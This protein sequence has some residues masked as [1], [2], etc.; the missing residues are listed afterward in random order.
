MESVKNPTEKVMDELALSWLKASERAENT[1]IFIW[2][3]P[4]GG[5]S[6]LEGF[7]ALQQHPQGRSLPDMFLAMTTPF[8]TGYGY[9]AALGR[10]FV[11][12]YE[13][14]PD[15]GDWD[16]E[17][18]LPCY[19]AAR[20][21]QLLQSF[22][23]A[24][25][26]A[27][28][29]LILVL[30][31]QTISDRS[32]CMR[33]LTRWLEQREIAPRLLLIDSLEQ[34][35]WQPLHQSHPHRVQLIVD[36]V[37]T[38]KVMHLTAQQLSDPDA[39]RLQFRRYLADAMLLLEKGGAEQV[40]AR[41]NMAL[42]IAR[43]RGW[44]DQQAII[45]NLMAGG[46]LKQGDHARAVEHYRQATDA[47]DH[48]ADPALKGQLRTQSAFGEAG[49]WFSKQ[50]YLQA[51]SGYRQAAREAQAIPHPL[52][53][54]EGWRMSGFCLWLAGHHARAMEEYALAVRAGRSIAA[55]ERGQSTLP[56]VFQD[57]LRIHDKPRTEAIEAC[58]ARWQKERQ[59]LIRQAEDSVSATPDITRVKQAEKRLQLQLEAAF[60]LIR[61]QRETLIA[62]SDAHFRR[63]IT[64]ARES[65][66]PHWNGLP[67]I[68]HPYDAPPGEW[69]TLP[70]WGSGSTPST[71]PAGSSSS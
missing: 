18:Y 7:I 28:R 42:D 68:A 40:A 46:W 54:T 60:I 21:S 10:E 31:P 49:A 50:A 29:Y 34:P 44:S 55:S 25:P 61:E 41:G 15:A 37:D 35:V 16:M 65:L 1:R 69:Q 19:S 48:L 53:E 23:G 71:D 4:A 52:F 47:S 67:D 8:D 51:A 30:K 70:G 11:E 24:F 36:D 33:W 66:H 17:P 45:H 62:R 64:L 3:A 6:L 63:V 59:R 27:L 2:R 39:D 20:L 22:A 9:S 13:A 38:M 26:D 32:A 43:R 56:L 14:T 12:H 58:A 57:L 5:E